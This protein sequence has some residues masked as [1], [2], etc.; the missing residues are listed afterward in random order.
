MKATYPGDF[1]RTAHAAL[2]DDDSD[3]E[4]DM[5]NLEDRNNAISLERETLLE[6]LIEEFDLIDE[7]SLVLLPG[8]VS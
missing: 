6:T 1:R 5:D 3:H 4:V 2:N 8:R 7:S